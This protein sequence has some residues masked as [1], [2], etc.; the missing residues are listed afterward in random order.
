MLWLIF[1]V[2]TAGAVVCVLWPLATSPRV[3]PRRDV[4]IAIYKAQV[5]EI[6]RDEAQQIATKEDAQSA[7][8]E[9]ARRLLATDDGN[10]TLTGESRTR[11]QLVSLAVLIFVPALSLAVYAATGHPGLPDA[12]LAARLQTPPER[13][14]LAAAIAKVEAHLARNPDDGRGYEV[15]VPVYIRMGRTADAVKA[16]RAALRL[17]G[18]SPARQTLFGE[19][20]V[21][22]AN[23][24]ITPEAEQSFA[25]AAT[26]E[27]SAPKP[28]FFLGLAAE[29]RGDTEAAKKLWSELAAELP[30]GSPVA[31][32]LGARIAALNGEPNQVLPGQVVNG[33]GAREAEQMRAIRAMVDGLAARLAQN[34][35]DIEGW[36]RL[37]RSYTV[38]RETEKARA[39][40]A[41]AKRNLAADPN[42]IA[43][44]EALARELGLEG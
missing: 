13:L 39:A 25:A 18:E 17:L 4:G 38:L 32:A 2:L 22:A 26:A 34:G 1:A 6:E 30:Q 9:A 43:R 3:I 31:Q 37:V 19:A 20:A 7:K 42:A 40:L 8:A 12:P 24:I 23:G 15:L 35:N 36:L 33:G 5:A 41:E 14:D 28:K 16:A 10:E 29:Q 21:A 11:A 27:P 44:I